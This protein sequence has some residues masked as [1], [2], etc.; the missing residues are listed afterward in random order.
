ML[1]LAG[2]G[3]GAWKDHGN[4]RRRGKGQAMGRE[5]RE[6][7]A[8]LPGDGPRCVFALVTTWD[9]QNGALDLAMPGTKLGLPARREGKLGEMQLESSSKGRENLGV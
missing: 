6:E 4:H 1:G 3:L 5:G 8:E 7:R 2:D 9:G